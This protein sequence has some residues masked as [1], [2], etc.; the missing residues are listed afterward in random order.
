L[1]AKIKKLF[2]KTELVDIELEETIELNKKHSEEFFKHFHEENAYI[3]SFKKDEKLTPPP[4]DDTKPPPPGVI[5]KIYRNLAKI[6]HPDVSK[7]DNAEEQFKKVTDYY[8]NHDLIKLIHLS[9]KYEIELPD[10]SDEDLQLIENK[11]TEKQNA[12][13]SI[14]QTLA[15][16]W[17][18]SK[19]D[20]NVLKEKIYAFL[21]INKEEFEKWKSNKLN[22]HQHRD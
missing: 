14:K 5:Q 10:L 15:W 19:E 11:I 13:D 3:I 1:Q 20:K 17:G 6:L 16:Y 12:V 7:V 4:K 2:L 18:N 8:E 21:G 9:L 22:G